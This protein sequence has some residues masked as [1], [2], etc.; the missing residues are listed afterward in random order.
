M[1]VK[2]IVFSV[3]V[4]NLLCLYYTYI[5]RKVNSKTL[6]NQKK[7]KKRPA[8]SF[9]FSLPTLTPLRIAGVVWT[10]LT[11]NIYKCLT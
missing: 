4:I 7:T 6:K 3:C 11:K 1:K 8:P 9:L 10:K 2:S 5:G